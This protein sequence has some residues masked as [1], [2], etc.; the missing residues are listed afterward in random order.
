MRTIEIDDQVFEFLG[1]NAIPFQET[2]PN[3]VLR[4]LLE[5]TESPPQEPNVPKSPKPDKTPPR[6]ISANESS[7]YAKIQDRISE[8]H[9]QTTHV[10]PAFLTFLMDKYKN[11]N[12]NFKTSDIFPFLDAVNLR[13]P[14]GKYRNPWMQQAYG[15]QKNGE[16]SCLRT[17]EHFR[18]TR[19]YGCWGG[20][21]QKIECDAERTCI[22]HPKNPDLI[23]N[24]CDL[25]RGVVWK[26]ATPS[27]PYSYGLK[28]VETIDR[29][30]LGGKGLAL[31]PLLAVFYPEDEFDDA[32][33]EI[34][35][36]DF[37]I[38][39]EEIKLFQYP[40]NCM[41]Q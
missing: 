12:G 3:M 41:F 26:R 15:G 5:L 21:D 11:T 34:F 40:T 2:S 25:E 37:N 38:T 20:R 23:K 27:A 13:H 1:K 39:D 8:L 24:K 17:I 6:L 16:Q 29:D 14:S 36:R 30:L 7:H 28:Y 9:R 31:E 4:R 19:R 22:Y 33:V 35:R 32:L 18:Q 10:K